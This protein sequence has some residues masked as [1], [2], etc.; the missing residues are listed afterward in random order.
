MELNLQNANFDNKVFQF[1]FGWFIFTLIVFSG[2]T[3][4]LINYIFYTTLAIFFGILLLKKLP[5][6]YSVRI[7]GSNLALFVVIF[8]LLVF[9]G[10]IENAKYFCILIFYFLLLDLIRHQNIQSIITLLKYGMLIFCIF[11]ILTSEKIFFENQDY[12]LLL[13]VLYWVDWILCEN[14]RKRKI[15]VDVFILILF[16]YIFGAKALLALNVLVGVGAI[17]KNWFSKKTFLIFL[18]FG[19]CLLYLNIGTVS[20]V[21]YSNLDSR[22]FLWTFFANKII[23]QPEILLFG[24]NTATILDCASEICESDAMAHVIALSL[25]HNTLVATVFEH[26]IFTAFFLFLLIFRNCKPVFK[27]R[28]SICLLA[29]FIYMMM[30]GRSFLALDVLNIS[31]FLILGVL[32]KIQGNVLHE[33]DFSKFR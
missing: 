7:N 8:F 15:I 27:S 19:C 32:I 26:G 30:N 18:T 25:P 16:C 13:S 5:K 20:T 28:L 11:V 9:R 6:N 33:G 2:G 17:N 21:I 10:E 4:A 12:I 31:F 22:F 29:V 1:F 24:A 3:F 14:Y 23:T